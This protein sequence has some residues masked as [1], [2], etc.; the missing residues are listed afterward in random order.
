MANTYGFDVV[1]DVIVG[2]GDANTIYGGSSLG[3]GSGNDTL[4]GAGGDD[5]LYGGFGNDPLSGD[6]GDDAL[7][8]GSDND[9]IDG[10]SGND[11]LD[12][13]VRFDTLWGGSGDDVVFG[14]LGD[15][16][17]YGAEGADT[18]YGGTDTFVDTIEGGEGNDVL[19]G[20]GG[21]DRFIYRPGPAGTGTDEIRDFNQGT[22]RIDVTAFGY[23]S[24]TDIIAAG[25]GMAQDGAWLVV[26]LA[27]GDHP[28]VVRILDITEAE[29]TAERF[30]F[31]AG[32]GTSGDDLLEGT[33]GADTL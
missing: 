8:G 5:T 10:G 1:N 15:D 26:T 31:V 25:G 23:S 4:S 21:S 28:V 11:T 19:Y 13:G 6:D 16:T 32:G 29:M 33:S 17:I 22:D 18:L 30:V 7:F 27:V 3:V 24:I 12:G 14:G 20:G 9:T 2:D